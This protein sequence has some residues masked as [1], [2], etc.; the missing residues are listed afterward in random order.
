MSAV[1]M[2][3][4]QFQQ[5]LQ[6]VQG[7]VAQRSPVAKEAQRI[8]AEKGYNR[9]TK[10]SHGEEEWVDWAYDF[11]TVLGTQCHQMKGLLEAVENE[12][13]VTNAGALYHKFQ[14]QMETVQAV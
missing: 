9:L 6:A 7:A 8:I 4:Q 5:F 1:A 11:K 10:F 2:D 14:G 13:A 3:A 12:K